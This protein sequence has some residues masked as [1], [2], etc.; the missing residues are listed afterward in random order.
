MIPRA[1]RRAGRDGRGVPLAALPARWSFR[2]LRER[3]SGD[4]AV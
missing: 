1:W 4:R 2:A 3:G